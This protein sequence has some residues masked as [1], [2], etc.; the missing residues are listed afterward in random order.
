MMGGGD[1]DG[2]VYWV[3]WDKELTNYVESIDHKEL[4]ENN[5][6]RADADCILKNICFV[7]AK[8]NLG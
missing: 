6:E 5:V 7:L 4:V 3:C 8:S 2:D 1:L